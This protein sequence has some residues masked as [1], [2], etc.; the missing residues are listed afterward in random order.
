MLNICRDNFILTN[1]V[2]SSVSP[3]PLSDLLANVWVSWE[4]NRFLRTKD[5]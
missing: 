5:I 1:L 2:G 4:K 3:A